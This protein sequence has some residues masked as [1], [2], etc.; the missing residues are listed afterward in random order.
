[1]KFQIMGYSN[2]RLCLLEL[3]DTKVKIKVKSWTIDPD[4]PDGSIG[5][6]ITPEAAQVAKEKELDVSLDGIL[7]K[8]KNG[9]TN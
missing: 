3:D 7:V 1:M 9:E 6:M 8:N 2:G 4:G 5:K